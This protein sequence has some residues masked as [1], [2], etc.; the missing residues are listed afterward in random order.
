MNR[1][2]KLRAGKEIYAVEITAESN[3]R[4]IFRFVSK[5]RDNLEDWFPGVGETIR[6][7]RA[8]KDEF[9]KPENCLVYLFG[10]YYRGEMAGL[11]WINGDRENPG[12]EIGYW[13]DPDYWGLGIMT[14][15]VKCA[16]VFCFCY[17]T[18]KVVYARVKP[19]NERSMSVLIQNNFRKAKAANSRKLWFCKSI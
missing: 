6:D 15:C 12:A 4:E 16:C 9:S 3:F 14:R 2:K 1:P 17:L 8:M 11:M 13:L 7:I 18:L 10:I 5:N 19:G